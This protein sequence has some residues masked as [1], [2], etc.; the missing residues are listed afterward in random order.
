METPTIVV[1]VDKRYAVREAKK[2]RYAV[3]KA[4]IGRYAVRKGGGGVTLMEL[5]DIMKCHLGVRWLGTTMQR[6]C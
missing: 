1:F 6:Y 5:N 2:K 3:R 4:K